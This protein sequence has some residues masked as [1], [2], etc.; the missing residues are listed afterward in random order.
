MAW[1]PPRSSQD[2]VELLWKQLENQP[3]LEVEVDLATQ[4]ITAGSLTIS[5]QVDPYIKWR[6]LNGLDDIALTLRHAAEIDEFEKHRPA[7]L[8][9]TG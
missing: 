8:P 1:S 4:T 6:L 9:T 7:F 2:D 5:F 3:G